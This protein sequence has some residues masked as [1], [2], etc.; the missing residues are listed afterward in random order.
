VPELTVDRDGVYWHPVSTDEDLL[1]TPH[2]LPL[3]AAV[4]R[5]TTLLHELA[6][7]EHRPRPYR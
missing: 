6:G 5:A 3:A 1:L 2:V 4:D 7:R